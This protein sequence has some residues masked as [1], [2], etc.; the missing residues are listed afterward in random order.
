[1][2]Y[3]QSYRQPQRRYHDDNGGLYPG[4]QQQQYVQQRPG[5][6]GQLNRFA[7]QSDGMNAS[8]RTGAAGGGY[9]QPQSM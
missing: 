6:R 7:S 5:G 8:F 4:E 2:A 3:D 9:E 1:M